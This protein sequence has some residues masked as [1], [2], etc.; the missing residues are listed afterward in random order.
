MKKERL[1][2]RPEE[3]ETKE[4]AKSALEGVSEDSFRRLKGKILNV[5]E[6][7]GLVEELSIETKLKVITLLKAVANNESAIIKKALFIIFD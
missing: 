7:L 6:E 1:R 4:G 2:I 3:I 5:I